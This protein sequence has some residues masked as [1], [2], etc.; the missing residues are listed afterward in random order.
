MK[1]KKYRYGRHFAPHDIQV[2]E[3]SSGT[4]E[5]PEIKSRWETA[6]LNGVTYEVVPA[7]NPQE[8]I[9]AVRRRFST[10][11]IDKTKCELG[12]KRLRRYHKEFDD[13][14]G[15]FKNIP[16]HDINS[17]CADSVGHWAITNFITDGRVSVFKPNWN[18]KGQRV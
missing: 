11:W 4:A 12:L 16:V 15:I 5:S 17:H 8:R 13:K 3:L 18:N 9:D 7:C 10:M 6:R 14:R 2:R 1:E